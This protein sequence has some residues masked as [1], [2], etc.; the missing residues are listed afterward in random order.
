MEH[1]SSSRVIQYDSYK[2]TRGISTSLLFS[3]F[4]SWVVGEHL[5]RG[6]DP[7]WLGDTFSKIQSAGMHLNCAFGPKWLRDTFSKVGRLWHMGCAFQ[8]W[9]V[10]EHLIQGFNQERLKER[11]GKERKGLHSCAC[12]RG[13]LS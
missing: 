9:E 7:K 2:M 6:F 10:N 3:A 12:L 1:T 13:Q 11:K 5:N 4:E 8:P